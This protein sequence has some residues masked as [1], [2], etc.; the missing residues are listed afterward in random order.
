M[1]RM[2]N[3]RGKSRHMQALIACSLDKGDD[4]WEPS[5]FGV[6][7]TTCNKRP[8]QADYD[9]SADFSIRNTR[10]KTVSRSQGIKRPL[11]DSGVTGAM[12]LNKMQR[13]ILKAGRPDCDRNILDLQSSVLPDSPNLD[14]PFKGATCGNSGTS[15]KEKSTERGIQ[16]PTCTGRCPQ[17]GWTIAQFL[18]FLP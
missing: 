6:R 1:R 18:Q 9:G 5:A 8:G 11:T 14:I 16:G 15:S 12:H 7:S 4:I 10:H 2:P 17:T 3:P 13:N